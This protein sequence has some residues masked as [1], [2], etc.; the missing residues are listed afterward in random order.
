MGGSDQGETTGSR[1]VEGPAVQTTSSA[2]QAE[3]RTMRKITRRQL[4]PETSKPGVIAPEVASARPLPSRLARRPN[5]LRLE[6]KPRP[7]AQ[8]ISS[9]PALPQGCSE[10]TRVSHASSHA[11]EMQHALIYACEHAFSHAFSH[12]CD[13]PRCRRTRWKSLAVASR[14]AETEKIEQSLAPPRDNITNPP[15]IARTNA[16]E[17]DRAIGRACD[18]ARSGPPQRWAGQASLPVARLGPTTSAA[19]GADPPRA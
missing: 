8:A 4:C 14:G 10:F 5:R 1:G 7:P 2:E 6:M 13:R 11:Y 3:L 15:D 19:S 12:A 16:R 18:Q 17:R 9:L